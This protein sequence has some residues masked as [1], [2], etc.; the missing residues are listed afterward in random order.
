M[1]LKF[2]HICL[3]GIAAIVTTADAENAE[4][5]SSIAPV[6][7]VAH[8]QGMDKA[9]QVLTRVTPVYPRELRER[10]VQGVVT[11]EML[12]DSSGRVIEA[13][14]VRSSTP[15]FASQAVAAA[16]EWT[17]VPAEAAGKK[18]TSRVRIPFEFTM[19]Q[20]AALESR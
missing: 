7:K 14:A 10:G 19:P 2:Y 1:K 11:V 15:E 17:F 13:D 16:K 8:I 20:I 12:I 3:V 5:T 6:A 18:I 9:P 4:D